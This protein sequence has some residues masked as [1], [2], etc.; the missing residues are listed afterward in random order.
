M[1]HVALVTDSAGTFATVLAQPLPRL[2]ED[3]R[4]LVTTLATFESEGEAQAFLRALRAVQVQ[5]RERMPQ[6]LQ[7]LERHGLLPADPLPGA[8]EH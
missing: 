7:A 2:V 1:I 4:I 8:R 5:R 3:G 6:D